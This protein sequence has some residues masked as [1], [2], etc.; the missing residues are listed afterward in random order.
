MRR[1]QTS[2]PVPSRRSSRRWR[3]SASIPPS[4]LLPIGCRPLWRPIPSGSASRSGCRAGHPSAAAGG[5]R[6]LLAVSAA[7][8]RRRAGGQRQRGVAQRLMHHQQAGT[9]GGLRW[10]KT[11]HQMHRC[12]AFCAAPL[13]RILPD[14]SP[15]FA[16]KGPLCGLSFWHSPC[17]ISI[18]AA[19]ITE[20]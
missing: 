12:G 17:F 14:L 18:V 10:C 4:W 16:I 11:L 1:R 6:P 9:L 13:R 5:E 8:G 3:R 20:Y 15:V 19:A 7:A 2:T